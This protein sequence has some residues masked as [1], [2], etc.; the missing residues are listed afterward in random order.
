MKYAVGIDVGGTNTRVAL[1]DENYKIIE[2]RQFPTNEEEP[3]TT[4]NDIKTVIDGFGYPVE[5]IGISCPGP[6]D[7]INGVVLT[8]PNLP[9]WHYFELTKCLEVKTGLSVHLENDGIWRAWLRQQSEQEKEKV[10]CSF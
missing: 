9:G 3:E 5:G 6:L 8:P 7:L 1:I 4:L 2:R 10:M